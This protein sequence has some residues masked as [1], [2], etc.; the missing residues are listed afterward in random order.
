[1]ETTLLIGAAVAGS[2]GAALVLQKAALEML[3]RAM[4][5]QRQTRR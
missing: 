5:H 3:L 2:F 1:M 4:D